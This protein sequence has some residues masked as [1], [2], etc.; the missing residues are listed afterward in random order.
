MG[1]DDDCDALLLLRA[2]LNAVMSILS[3]SALAL[4]GEERMATPLIADVISASLR[5][6]C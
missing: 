6:S 3:T 4:H 1:E 2:A 5:L